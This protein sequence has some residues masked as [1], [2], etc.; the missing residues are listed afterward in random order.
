[1]KTQISPPNAHLYVNDKLIP[2]ELKNQPRWIC[3]KRAPS[4]SKPGKFQKV[5]YDAKTGRHALSNDSTTWSSFDAALEAFQTLSYD[6]VGFQLGGGFAG[7]DLDS[8]VDTKTG[9]IAD[10]ALEIID[11][12]KTYTETSPSGTGLKLFLKGTLPPGRRRLDLPDGRIEFY[13]GKQFFTVTGIRFE[14]ISIIRSCNPDFYA[15]YNQYC[16]KSPAAEHKSPPSAE[17]IDDGVERLVQE[18]QG[19]TKGSIKRL[20]DGDQSGY[21]SQSEADLALCAMLALHFGCDAATYRFVC[22][23]D[24]NFSGRNGMRST[25]RAGRTYGLHDDCEGY[26]HCVSRVQEKL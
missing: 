6:G 24:Q 12:L 14:K 26:S 15:V 22:S 19:M 13:D 17:K 2:A 10:W 18:I 23:V 5:P 8:C 11:C 21:G 4:K 9:A 1:M 3:W 7:I 20:W 16:G 25:R